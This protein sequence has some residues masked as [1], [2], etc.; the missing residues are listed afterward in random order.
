MNWQ[1]LGLFFRG[2][3]PL[4]KGGLGFQTAS[5]PVGSRLA[6]Q[7]QDIGLAVGVIVEA[8]DHKLAVD[9]MQ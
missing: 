7:R 6:P 3:A 5:D 9:G 8:I 1:R 2:L 4:S